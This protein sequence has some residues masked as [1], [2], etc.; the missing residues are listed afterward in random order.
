MLV[1]VPMD[2]FSADLPV[3]AFHQMPT[4]MARPALD[5]ATVDADRPRA[6]R[7]RAS[8]ALRGRRRAVGPRDRRA[9]GAR[10]GARRAG[11]AH[12]DGQGLP[13][14]GPPAAARHD[15]LL[16]HADRQREVPHRRPDS[17]R[18]HAAR[19][20]ELELVGP[21]LHVR[22]S[23]DAPDPHRRRPRRDR[24][25][26]PDR[27]RRRRRREARARRARGGRGRRAPPRPRQPARRDRATAA[28]RSRP[29][30]I[31][32]GPPISIRCGPSGS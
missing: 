27:A 25:Q 22:D 30:G 18:R 5:P 15:R 24:P 6:R 12:A 11:R 1:D 2:L 14:R 29:T 28:G 21:A 13:A 31:T 4:P 32:S 26:L 9:H 19:R 20:G 23:A 17:R 3:D 8:G 16:G 7:R 10:R